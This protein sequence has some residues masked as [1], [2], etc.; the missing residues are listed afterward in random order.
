MRI[1]YLV[2]CVLAAT[3]LSTLTVRSAQAQ[4]AVS[5]GINFGSYPDMVG[6]PGLPV[7]YAPGLGYNYF[8]SDGLFWI[9]S[10]DLWYQSAWYNGPWIEVGPDGVPL[11]LLRVP[12]RYYRRPPTYFS[13]WQSNR[14][15]HWDEHWGPA[16]QQQRQGW[17]REPVNSA[18]GPLPSYQRNYQGARYPAPAQQQSLA[19]QNDHG[20]GGN[21]PSA[22]QHGSP[23]QLRAGPGQAGVTAG[24]PAEQ[25]RQAPPQAQR[26]PEQQQ[27]QAPP[28]AQ[29]PPEQQQRQAPPQ[30]QRPAEQQQRQAPPQMERQGGTAPQ[31][32]DAGPGRG[33]AGQPEEGRGRDEHR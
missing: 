26:P 29:R 33:N 7:Y 14:A 20:R 31:N 22:E 3:L 24:R 11:Y 30:A 15:P 10:G 16:W 18:R 8:F 12:V 28:Q 21:P 4:V 6:V 32:R 27:R 25:Q 1:R 17:D 2:S 5:I 19:Q 13:A 23:Q 9:Y